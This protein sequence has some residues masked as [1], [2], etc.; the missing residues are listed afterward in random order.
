MSLNMHINTKHPLQ[1]RDEEEISSTEIYHNL[2]G[3]ESIDDFFKLEVSD[4]DQIYACSV[5]DQGLDI[6]NKRA[7]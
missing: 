2:D 3:I 6:E 7:V 5:F 1:N 4:G